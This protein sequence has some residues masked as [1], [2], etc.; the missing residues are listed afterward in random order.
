MTTW[1]TKR[2]GADEPPRRSTWFGDDGN[3]GAFRR[4]TAETP[5]DDAVMDAAVAAEQLLGTTRRTTALT[6]E[7]ALSRVRPLRRDV[8]DRFHDLDD[9]LID[10]DVVTAAFDMMALSRLSLRSAERLNGVIGAMVGVRSTPSTE[11]SSGAGR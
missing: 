9:D 1:R 4:H 3:E 2:S 8:R 11:D 10:D 7:A 6:L 5:P